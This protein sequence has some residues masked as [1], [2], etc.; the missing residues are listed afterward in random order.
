METSTRRLFVAG[1]TGATGRNVVRQ[2]LARG[3]HVTAHLRPK[4][5]SSE[6]ARDWP[7][8]AVVELTDGD[9]LA[10]ALRGHTTVLQLIGTMR[11]R[12]A[13]GDTYE[14]SDIGTTRQ[15]V[16]AAKRAGVDHLVL[17]SS[18]GAGRPVG[19]YLKAKAEA[20]RLVRDSGI[21]YTVVRPPAFE[22]E[23]HKPIPFL[24]TLTRLP[25]LRGMRPIRIEQLAAVLLRVSEQRAP[26]GAV[27]E[28]DSLWAEVSAAGM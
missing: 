10:E 23:Y 14:T 6:L 13:A 18:V 5:A 26:L 16:E 2:G 20:E 8:K 25:L 19:A 21:P 12:F 7:H 15:L 3:V 22:G 4:S 9:T 11:K 1:A 27:L 24:R 28:G 17:L